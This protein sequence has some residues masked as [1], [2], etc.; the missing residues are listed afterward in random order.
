MKKY[1]LYD[2]YDYFG[3]HLSKDNRIGECDTKEEADQIAQQHHNDC[4]GECDIWICPY[5]EEQK[6]YLAI[7]AEPFEY[8]MEDDE[9]E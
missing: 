4:D 1:R 2:M 8:E 6:K 7:D 5:N 9:D 3:I